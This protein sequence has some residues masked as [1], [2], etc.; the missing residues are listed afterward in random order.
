MFTATTFAKAL[1][2]VFA[3]YYVMDIEYF[4]I[5]VNSSMEQLDIA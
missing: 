3:W 2:A 5:Q 4:S 1:V